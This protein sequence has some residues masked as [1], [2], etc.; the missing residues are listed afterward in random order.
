MERV[1][2]I[3][4]IAGE[5]KLWKTVRL[6]AAMLG[7]VVDMLA[8]SVTSM[9]VRG[10]DVSGLSLNLECYVHACSSME[11]N[12]INWKT[13]FGTKLK[14][15][16]FQNQSSV[17]IHNDGSSWCAL[18]GDFIICL[19]FYYTQVTIG[20]FGYPE[21]E[22]SEP[23]SPKVLA[24]LIYDNCLPYDPIE[25]VLQQEV[26]TTRLYSLF[27]PLRHLFSPPPP[28]AHLLHRRICDL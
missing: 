28:P 11:M 3:Y 7:K 26:R 6:A 9:L 21:Q 1:N 25:A 22:I 27:P 20:V 4:G 5:K 15:P 19:L 18:L 16:S 10:K 2:E 14:N 23:L 12:Q 13:R 24:K 8:P 17:P